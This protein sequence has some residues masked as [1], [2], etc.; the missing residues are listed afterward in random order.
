[1]ALVSLV[2]LTRPAAA[3]EQGPVAGGPLVPFPVAGPHSFVDDFGVSRP[4]GRTH[5]GIDIF[6]NKMIPVVAIADGTVEWMH[7][8][9]GG[10]CCALGIR[11]SNGWASWYIHL[12]NDS[13]GTDDGQGWG[14]AGGIGLGSQ[15]QAGMVIGWVGDSGNAESTPPH[16]HFELHMPDGTV[17]NP[18]LQLRAAVAGSIPAQAF[19]QGSGVLPVTGL[20]VTQLG[21]LGAVLVTLGV[22][23]LANAPRRRERLR[24]PWPP[25]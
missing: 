24:W 15:V 11:H 22:L 20:P 10:R 17:V 14:F 8:E 13:P 3:Q 25:P 21:G 1:M 16:L 9:R 19:F 7:D 12:N 4:G 2:A 23:L 18:Y 6:A 5:H